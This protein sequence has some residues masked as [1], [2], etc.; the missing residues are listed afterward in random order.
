MNTLELLKQQAID[1]TESVF[2]QFIKSANM[3]LCWQARII[4][5]NELIMML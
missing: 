1:Q 4:R 5:A 3:E 2:T